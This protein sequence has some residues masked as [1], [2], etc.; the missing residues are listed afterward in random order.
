MHF[1]P[2]R[3][4]ARRS[5]FPPVLLAFGTAQ[6]VAQIVQRG[7][8]PG[9]GDQLVDRDQSDVTAPAQGTVHLD[10]P[11]LALRRQVE[12]QANE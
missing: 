10:M 7:I 8:R 5:T 12:G 4:Q 2:I 9:L 1:G 6:P 11:D 3:L